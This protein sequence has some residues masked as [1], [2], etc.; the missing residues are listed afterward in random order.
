MYCYTRTRNATVTVNFVISRL[1]NWR[2]VNSKWYLANG[3]YEVT[4][5]EIEFLDVK[6]REGL[7]F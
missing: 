7:V 6:I 3:N 4:V 1:K 2:D 5:L